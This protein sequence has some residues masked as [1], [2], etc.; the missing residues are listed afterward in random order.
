MHW[1]VPQVRALT[2][3][4]YAALVQWLTAQQAAT[5]GEEG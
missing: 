5:R 4:Q 2:P 1:T 3:N